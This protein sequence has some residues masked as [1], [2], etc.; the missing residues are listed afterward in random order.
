MQALDPLWSR[1]RD[2]IKELNV[3]QLQAFITE[4]NN[5]DR[6]ILNSAHPSQEMIDSV[7]VPSLR[8]CHLGGGKCVMCLLNYLLQ[9][10]GRSDLA[11]QVKRIQSWLE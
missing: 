3:Q 1:I 5:Y 4:I 2:I 8:R 7:I 11:D 6:A 10:I 9:R